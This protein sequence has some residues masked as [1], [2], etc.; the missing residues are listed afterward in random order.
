MTISIVRTNYKTSVSS[1]CYMKAALGSDGQGPTRL[2]IATINVFLLSHSIIQMLCMRALWRFG[3]SGPG[4]PDRYSFE[5]PHPHTHL[6]LKK[7]RVRAKATRA[8]FGRLRSV[9]QHLITAFRRLHC[10]FA[11]GKTRS[12]CGTRSRSGTILLEMNSCPPR[13]FH[14]KRCQTIR[15]LRRI[16]TRATPIETPGAGS[17][18]YWELASWGKNPD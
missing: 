10:L 14:L 1:N 12:S 7:K 15:K 13:K 8:A 18:E 16:S 17:G 2:S 5:P 9:R 3:T 4:M 11:D 6:G